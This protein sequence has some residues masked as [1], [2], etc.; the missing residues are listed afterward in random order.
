M[1]DPATMLDTNVLSELM[2]A[3]ANP[4]VARFVATLATPLVSVAVFHELGYGVELL[5]EG[6]RKA[7]MEARIGGLKAHF[8]DLHAFHMEASVAADQELASEVLKDMGMMH[9][10]ITALV[11]VAKGE[12]IALPPKPPKPAATTASK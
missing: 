3:A 12:G 5:P 4:N 10:H 7:R 6:A 8:E 9:Q 1:T 11:N 2:R